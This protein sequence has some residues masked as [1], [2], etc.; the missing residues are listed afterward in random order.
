MIIILLRRVIVVEKDTVG[1]EAVAYELRHV[2]GENRRGELGDVEV[3]RA[4][5]ADLDVGQRG[6]QP[7]LRVEVGEAHVCLDVLEGAVELED[8]VF[9]E[10]VAVAEDDGL[11]FAAATG[12]GRVGSGLGVDGPLHGGQY[13]H[14]PEIFLGFGGEPLLVPAHEVVARVRVRGGAAPPRDALIRGFIVVYCDDLIE[15]YVR[16]CKEEEQEREGFEVISCHG[17]G[18][19]ARVV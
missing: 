15:T 7:R 18:L 12:S 6:A 2:A 10:V 9:D 8:R 3:E 4:G 17:Y 11:S 19:C 14:G 5:A 13:G 1:G 16:N